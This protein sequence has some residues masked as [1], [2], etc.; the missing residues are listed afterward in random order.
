MSK[1]RK[2]FRLR[3]T[4]G[5]DETHIDEH[6]GGAV[7]TEVAV[8]PG[9]S[10]NNKYIQY[11][12]GK[13]R[14]GTFISPGLDSIDVS[15]TGTTWSSGGGGI[16]GVYAHTVLG[17][18]LVASILGA[19]VELHYSDNAGAAWLLGQ[20]SI[21]AG[22]P[23]EFCH[24]GSRLVRVAF[25]STD[26]L[27]TSDGAAWTTYSNFETFA[28]APPFSAADGSGTILIAG[29][30]VSTGDRAFLRST[31]HGVSWA[32]RTFVAAG[33]PNVSNS[34]ESWGLF[35]DGAQFVCLIKRDDLGE[36]QVYTSP[37]GLTWAAGI[38]IPN[39]EHYP[40]QIID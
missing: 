34:S 36:F 10:R 18:R 29:N 2:V 32:T 12:A 13:L 8:V 14:A 9:L 27:S 23:H 25:G 1:S 6:E 31:N 38:F 40:T 11:L 39:V 17:T 26:V 24:S 19:S 33:I 28:S 15:D 7:F 30:V 5:P 37:T 3:F 4:T 35:W 21:D 16:E 22:N 20:G